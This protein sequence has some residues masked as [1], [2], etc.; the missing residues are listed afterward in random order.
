LG[1]FPNK[2]LALLPGSWRFLILEFTWAFETRL[3][4]LKKKTLKKIK[5]FFAKMSNFHFPQYEH[6]LFW[7]YY[8]RLHAFLAHSS[9]FLGTWELLDTIYLGVNYKTHAL[10]K[11]WDF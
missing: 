10:L 8:D 5:I 11:Q 1:I 4:F 2:F 3:L 7:G 6:E 9:Y